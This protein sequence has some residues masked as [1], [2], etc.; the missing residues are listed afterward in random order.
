MHEVRKLRVQELLKRTLGEIIRREV[1]LHEAGLVSVN[2]VEVA[3]DLQ[4]ATVY[5]GIV[6]DARQ[7]RAGLALLE[8]DAKLFQ[9]QMAQ[10]VVLKYTPRLKF[11]LD[12]SI[13]RGNRILSIIE[14]LEQQPPK[15]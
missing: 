5:V 4:S 10:A 15:S 13:E 7:Q 9:N 1:P 2:S 12:D 8:R 14:E 11:V 3:S 6:G